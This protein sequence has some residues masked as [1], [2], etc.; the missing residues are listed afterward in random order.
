MKKINLEE[1]NSHWN[2]LIHLKGFYILE[3]KPFKHKQ[4]NKQIEIT[5]G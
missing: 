1:E 2:G 3:K 5:S 4:T